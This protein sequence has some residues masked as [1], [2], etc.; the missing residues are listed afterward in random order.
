MLHGA[1]LHDVASFF[2]TM[3]PPQPIIA[4]DYAAD[5]LRMLTL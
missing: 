1:Y 4:A 5:A 3:M 2:A